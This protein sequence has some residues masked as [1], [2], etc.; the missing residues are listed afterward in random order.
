[1][2]PSIGSRSAGPSSRGS[3]PPC[4]LGADPARRPDR[5]RSGRTRDH[6]ADRG[7][8]PGGLTGPVSGAVGQEGRQPVEGA[9]PVGA[10]ITT[11][12]TPLSPA[13]SPPSPL[14]GGSWPT[15]AP[16]S[17]SPRT[18]S[19]SWTGT[20]T[21]TPSTPRPPP[22][23]GT[24]CSP[25]SPPTSSA[26]QTSSSSTRANPSSNAATATSKAPS[27]SRHCSCTATTCSARKLGSKA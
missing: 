22:M 20:T 2:R 7:V 25:T 27:P 26:P 21:R 23:A 13:R 15:C 9:V 16:S 3:T 19:R 24:P 6:H 12:T 1:M 8:P 4:S 17:P 10:P 11:P 14:S 18:A 5:P